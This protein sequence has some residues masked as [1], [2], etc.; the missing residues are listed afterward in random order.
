MT[1]EAR[2]AISE[3]SVA[4]KL[5]GPL[6]KEY[7][8][9]ALRQTPEDM[10]ESVAEGYRMLMAGDWLGWEIRKTRRKIGFLEMLPADEQI[11]ADLSRERDWLAALE[12]EQAARQTK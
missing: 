2:R 9:E 6:P 4:W 1:K 3:L 10:R 5:A 7:A 8:D 11:T 12:E